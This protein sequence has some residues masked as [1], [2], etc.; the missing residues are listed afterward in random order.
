M[1]RRT[2]VHG[3]MGI[4]ACPLCAGLL[5]RSA[6]ASDAKPH[7]SYEGS[8]GPAA[9]GELESAYAV[10]G[11]GR[12]QSPIDLSHAIT[13]E[14]DAASVNWQPISHGI[15]LN[16]GHTIQINTPDA[17]GLSLDGAEY[18]LAQFHFHH[19]SEHAVDGKRSPMEVHFVHKAT[20]GDGLT[21]LGVF[22]VEGT[23]N[24]VLAPLW[25]AMPEHEGEKPLVSSIDAKGLLPSSSA[26]YRYEGSLTTPPCSEIVNWVVLKEPVTASAAQIA[27]FAKLFP[28]NARPIQPLN[29]RFILS[30]Q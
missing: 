8:N 21:V 5:G 27:A 19:L 1:N 28:N 15:I 18:K 3:V 4:V 20:S 6:V 25:A 17:G 23:E 10:C 22:L 14:L 11:T 30:I 26:A 2:F 29:R 13:A 24:S 9:W 12:Q 7:W 16:N